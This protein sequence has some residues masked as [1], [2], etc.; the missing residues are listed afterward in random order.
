MGSKR[1][2]MDGLF[3]DRKRPFYNFSRRMELGRLPYEELGRF[4]EERFGAAGKGI[5]PEAA[6]AL[7]GL[8]R[9]HPYRAQQLAS[10][11]FDLCRAEADEE[12][13]F[14]AKEAA[15]KE[16]EPELRAILD[17]MERPRRAVLIALCK[18]PVR[19]IY[20]R[21]YMQRHGIRGYGSLRSALD[22]LVA[23]GDVEGTVR[24]TAGARAR[25]F[26]PT[27]CSPR[28]CERG[29]TRARDRTL[30]APKDGDCR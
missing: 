23:S 14:A 18:E 24:G 20:S 17:T 8:A 28:G 3:S 4:V 6:D 1:S 9:G 7:I 19:E 25:P 27:R 22:A 11:A 30:G 29:W 13:V 10:H 26:R 2:L 21:P 5:I 12:T 16:A 15:H